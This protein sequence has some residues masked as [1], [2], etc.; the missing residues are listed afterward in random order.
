M[1][2]T[3]LSLTALLMIFLATG[4]GGPA[5]PEGM[6]RLYPASVT[7]VQEGTPLAG[8]MVQLVSDEPELSRWG[9][10]GITDAAGVAVLKTNGTYD[11]AP[12]GKFKAIVS[13]R[14]R[15][16]HPNPEW[17]N[18]PDG[19]PNFQKYRQAEMKRKTFNYVEPK[20]SSIADSPLTLE[21]T[22]DGKTY[23]LDVG[24]QTKAE[25]KMSQ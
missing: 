12:L 7:V 11:G 25:V 15:E 14:E 24:K 18:L 20:Y 13:K 19:D 3:L 10:S 21:I 6:P 9:P 1:N 2:R 4:C 8:A 23:S 16:P 5:R 17:A 22:A